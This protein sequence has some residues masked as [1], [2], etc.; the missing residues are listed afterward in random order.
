MR[1]FIPI[2]LTVLWSAAG[3]G[4]GGAL[5]A[6]AEEVPPPA[7]AADTLRLSVEDAVASALSRGEP[8]AM[9]REDIRIAEAQKSEAFSNA[10]PKVSFDAIYNRNLKSPVIFFPD[11]DGNNQA[12]KLGEDNE[13]SATLSLSQ[14]LYTFGRVS[15]AYKAFKE[16]A[17]AAHA[18]GDA[19]AARIALGVRETY[20]GALLARANLHIAEASLLQADRRRR[21]IEMR[22]DRGVLPR[23]DLLRAQVEVANRGPTVTAARHQAESALEALKR[24]AGLPLDRPVALTDTLGYRPFPDSRE[25]AVEEALAQRPELDASTRGAEAARLLARAQAAN[26][27]PLLYLNGNYTWQGQTSDGFVPGANESAE[28]AAIGL[29]LSWPLWDGYE[30]RS[31]AH[32]AQARAEKARLGLR[33]L[34]EQVRLEART[35]W[36]NVR[37]IEEE[38]TGLKES[39]RL[40]EETHAIAEVRYES[41]LSILIEV[42]E[43]DLALTSARFALT[44]A[45]YRYETALAELETI[46]GRGPALNLAGD[47]R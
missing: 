23:F 25:Q 35:A 46:L 7:A 13:Y 31:R 17:R 44:E 8:A 1:R 5:P 11:E 39:V 37:S 29:A 47:E 27:M 16:S 22:V 15:S 38:L 41:G 21:G 40:A 6:L 10:L 3:L 4:T 43:T 30:N 26:A 45:L 28:S 12:I 33:Q 20:Y 24:V 34:E 9:A 32:Q 14:P 18:G 19:S 2:L 42:L 36:A